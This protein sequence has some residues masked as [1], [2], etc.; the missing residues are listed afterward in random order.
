MISP[1]LWFGSEEERVASA[2]VPPL[3]AIVVTERAAYLGD[4]RTALR[5]LEPVSMAEL[6]ATLRLMART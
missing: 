1:E 6:L 2:T 4:A 3:N 5:H